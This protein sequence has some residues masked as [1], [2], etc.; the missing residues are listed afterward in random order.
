MPVRSIKVRLVQ[1][2]TAAAQSLLQSLWQTHVVLNEAVLF[3]TSRLL[4]MR[5]GPYQP[6][7]GEL[8][9]E[10]ACIA[11]LDETIKCALT[12]N[13]ARAGKRPLT[14][15]ECD[16]TLDEARPWLRRLDESIIPPA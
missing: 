9:S 16:K 5:A 14:A 2:K 10:S 7:D 15:S 1:P 8:I 4:E 11:R 3:Y 6:R 13:R 12:N